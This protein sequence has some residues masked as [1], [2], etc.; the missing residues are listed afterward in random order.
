MMGGADVKP[1][2]K[3]RERE[4]DVEVVRVE[5]SR[6]SKGGDYP[7]APLVATMPCSTLDPKALKGVELYASRDVR[8]ANVVVGRSSSRDGGLDFV[9]STLRSIS[10]PARFVVMK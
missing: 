9:G 6:G 1:S 7:C 4:I 5:P 2:T 8:D 10:S 3:K